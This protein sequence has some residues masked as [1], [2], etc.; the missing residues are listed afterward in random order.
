MGVK[1]SLMFL[2]IVFG[3]LVDFMIRW[4]VPSLLTSMGMILV[5]LGGALT[6]YFGKREMASNLGK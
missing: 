4:Q 6:I 1:T 5:I 3:V 2:C